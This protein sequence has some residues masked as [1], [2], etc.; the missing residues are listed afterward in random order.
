MRIF[1]LETAARNTPKC[2]LPG[3]F[4]AARKTSDFPMC[5]YMKGKD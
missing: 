1:K 3:A 5:N 4:P 2:P